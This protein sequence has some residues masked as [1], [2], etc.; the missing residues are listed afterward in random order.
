MSLIDRTLAEN[1]TLTD[2]A[3]VRVQHGTDIAWIDP[4]RYQFVR[5]LLTGES[6][7]MQVESPDAV[8]VTVD[9]VPANLD[10]PIGETTKT[11]EV[12]KALGRKG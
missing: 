12:R 5:Q 4:K 2:E 7:V 6:P 9:G 10:T 8:L 3:S 1:E 11:V